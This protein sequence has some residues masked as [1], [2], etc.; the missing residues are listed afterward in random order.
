M[1]IAQR[2]GITKF[3]FK[4]K[5]KKGKLLYVESSNGFFERA[6]YD[7]NN[8]KIYYNIGDHYTKMQY[9]DR[10]QLTHLLEKNR[11]GEITFW[12]VKEYDTNGK[13]VYFEN[14][15]GKIRNNRPKT[16]YTLL[17]IAQIIGIP[18][19]KLKILK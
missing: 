4:V 18:I 1:T 3:P 12:Y 7:K 16:E 17:E 14:S 5:N 19:E 10:N 9:N 13:E 8:N 6:R 2:L 15:K 11:D